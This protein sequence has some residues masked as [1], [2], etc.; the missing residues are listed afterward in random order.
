MEDTQKAVFCELPTATMAPSD[1]GQLCCV[2]AISITCVLWT[3]C[4]YPITPHMGDYPLII[5]TQGPDLNY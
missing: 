1:P 5:L 2:P 4:P 3:A